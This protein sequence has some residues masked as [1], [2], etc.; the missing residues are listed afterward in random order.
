M[1]NRPGLTSEGIRYC[2]ILPYVGSNVFIQ[3]LE[4]MSVS[5]LLHSSRYQV[6]SITEVPEP[7]STGFIIIPCGC[8]SWVFGQ[9]FCSS[10]LII[11]SFGFA[12]GYVKL[13]A[14]K[15]MPGVAVFVK[16]VLVY[17]HAP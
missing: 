9:S 5:R 14:S 17:S 3:A 8:F 6:L 11:N 10:K 13:T 4:L 12:S 15:E 2:S 1:Q 16:K 7:L